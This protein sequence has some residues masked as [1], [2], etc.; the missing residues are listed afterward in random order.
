MPQSLD[1]SMKRL[2]TAV[3]AGNIK[4]AEKLFNKVMNT[5]EEEH[6]KKHT[7]PH[8]NFTFKHA[9]GKRTRRHKRRKSRKN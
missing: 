1:V 8:K 7:S 3:K 2:A 4:K 9:G 5:V 6:K